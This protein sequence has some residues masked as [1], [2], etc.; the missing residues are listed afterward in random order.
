MN[1][2]VAPIRLEAPLSVEAHLEVGTTGLGIAALT[3]TP[4]ELGDVRPRATLE[5]ERHAS[6]DRLAVRRPIGLQGSDTAA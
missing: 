5:A 2:S 1:A 6:V 4:E 3:A